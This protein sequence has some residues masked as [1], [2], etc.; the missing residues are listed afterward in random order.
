MYVLPNARRVVHRLVSVCFLSVL[1]VESEEITQFRRSIDLGLP[2][3]LSLSDHG[4][5][6]DVIS[7]LG[8]NQICCLEEDSS[9]VGE[10]KVRP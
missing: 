4:C 3:I 8:R 1:D 5:S 2:C 10:R 6:H 7:V 9:A